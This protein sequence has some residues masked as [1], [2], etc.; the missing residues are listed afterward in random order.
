MNKHNGIS[1]CGALALLAAAA[2]LAGCATT[3]RIAVV[4]NP[5]VGYLYNG[6]VHR[7]EEQA[8]F[9]SILADE[10]LTQ[11]K[12]EYA[13]PS[14]RK[15]IADWERYHG[16]L[17][18]PIELSEK[19]YANEPEYISNVEVRSAI[20]AYLASHPDILGVDGA[21]QS[22]DWQRALKQAADNV[23]KLKAA[24]S[25]GLSTASD[26]QANHRYAD[27]MVVLREVSAYDPKN[28][29]LRRQLQETV[30]YA[31]TYLTQRAKES[32]SK[33]QGMALGDGIAELSA[34]YSAIVS[35]QKELPQT[36]RQA[37]VDE[38]RAAL[39]SNL[40]EHHLRG[41]RLSAHRKEYW[42][43][44]LYVR[45]LMDEI[46]IFHA[47]DTETAAG[48][49]ANAYAEIL[50][51]AMAYY[52]DA[53]RARF[54][55]DLYGYA[56]TLYGMAAAMYDFAIEAG[57]ETPLEAN[58]WDERCKAELNAVKTK[59]E[60][61]LRRRLVVFDF[62][63][64]TRDSFDGL[65]YPIRTASF[66]RYEKN[67][68][69]MAW[70][71]TVVMAQNLSPASL[72]PSQKND[73]F[74]IL[75][76]GTIRDNSITPEHTQEIERS[77][78]L[79][80]GSTIIEE[81]NPFRGIKGHELRSHATLFSQEVNKYDRIVLRHKREANMDVLVRFQYGKQGEP[82]ELYAI[83]ERYANLDKVVLQATEVKFV[84]PINAAPRRAATRNQLAPDTLPRGEPARL[85][86]NSDIEKALGDIVVD[87]VMGKIDQLILAFPLDPL[88]AKAL[89]AESGEGRMV[90]AADYWGLTWLY[91]DALC[92]VH[93]DADRVRAPG[94]G[95]LYRQSVIQNKVTQWNQSR[96]A[97][98]SVARRDM[99][100]NLWGKCVQSATQGL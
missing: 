51:D 55:R 15:L 42:D 13:P 32:I 77:E 69:D 82:Q 25:T 31:A 79:I 8:A 14:G 1:I 23:R 89:S 39:L 98:Q 80:G 3:P 50:P 72:A 6:A 7:L 19:D 10:R 91:L 9:A 52:M 24:Q 12:A 99:L 40:L 37:D 38:L 81:H 30:Q 18:R 67:A 4:E 60:D 76:S 43:V 70:A 35:Y 45:G 27:A 59:A 74:D 85:S 75:V 36:I 16:E 53:G 88:L 22:R 56:Y 65:S 83:R 66:D 64:I 94:N 90:E 34:I 49:L 47:D 97:K 86:S 20:D 5:V 71:L 17:E 62:N 33:S 41:I 100:V 95:W 78:V 92:T 93:Y 21:A 61:Y 48:A 46:S 26:H 68:N 11:I 2:W 58:V 44:Y 96:W 63:L 28:D 57:F 73:E 84:G 29:R 54:I 87:G